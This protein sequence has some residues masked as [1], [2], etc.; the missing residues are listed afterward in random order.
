[1]GKKKIVCDVCFNAITGVDAK[2]LRRVGI[3][4]KC[5][6]NSSYFCQATTDKGSRCK[7]VGE[8]NGFC[9]VHAK[10]GLARSWKQSVADKQSPL[11]SLVSTMGLL[12][13]NHVRFHEVDEVYH[14]SFAPDGFG[15]VYNIREVKYSIM[16]EC[17]NRAIG[18]RTSRLKILKRMSYSK[19]LNAREWRLKRQILFCLYDGCQLCGKSEDSYRVH[20]NN[21]FNKPLEKMADLVV[22]CSNCHDSYHRDKNRETSR[23]SLRVKVG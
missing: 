13:G 1:M 16:F 19:Y 18:A 6:P 20:H 22:L 21:Y 12:L 14:L 4:R 15:H 10:I 23:P 5:A 7:Y 3:C 8:L 11:D 17:L 2:R 9:R